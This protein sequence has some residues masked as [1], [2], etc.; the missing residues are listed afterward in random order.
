MQV[1]FSWHIIIISSSSSSIICYFKCN[2]HQ[3]YMNLC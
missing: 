1:S 3:I 2:L